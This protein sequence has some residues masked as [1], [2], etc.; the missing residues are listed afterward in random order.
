M[1]H[2]RR[3]SQQSEELLRHPLGQQKVPAGFSG[4]RVTSEN[5]VGELMGVEVSMG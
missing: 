4:K 3:R 5:S 2:G 1:F